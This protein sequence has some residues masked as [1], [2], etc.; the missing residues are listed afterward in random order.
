M[1]Y[2]VTGTAGNDTLNQVGDAGPGTIV[3]L[4]GNDE[5]RTG[6]GAVT[7]DGGSGEDTT[8]LQ[9]GNTGQVTGGV[10]NDSIW[11]ANQNIGSMVLFGNEGADTINVDNSTNP[12]TILGGNDSADAND[13]IRGGGAADIIFGHGGDDR[14]SA[15]NGNDTY[16]A[17]FGNDFMFDPGAGGNDLVFANEGNDS[18]NVWGGNDTVFAGQGND[19]AEVGGGMPTY[20]MNEGNDTFDGSTNVQ[21]MTVVGGNDS[22]DGSD[23]ILTGTGDDL[24]F[25]NGG[26]DTLLVGTGS[27]T[28]IGGAG[29][30]SIY[31]PAG[32]GND[33][34]FGNEGNDTINTYPGSD[35]VFAG[36]GN[37]SVLGN[38][39]TQSYL[40]GEGNDTLRGGDAI[41]TIS[42][43]SG[44]DVFAYS[45][46]D[47]DGNNA[48]AGGPIE[49]L[50]DVNFDED[51]FQVVEGIEFAANVGAIAGPNLEASAES[52][53]QAA[54]ALGGGGAI[55][56]AA[57]FSFNGHTYLAINQGGSNVL[58]TDTFDL[59][60]DI[61]GATGTIGTNDFFV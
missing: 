9:A 8:I 52:A 57:Q 40:G 37:D 33:L 34:V 44:A 2:T 25:G 55:D 31:T 29:D 58:F 51:R 39:G 32:S 42:G 46:A 13:S 47:D 61:T 41:D 23:S 27:N 45:D 11:D 26:N 21:A 20:F 5:I 48:N 16:V 3:G 17:G 54:V 18:M 4:A 36:Q 60:F 43:G 56:V 22:N 53:I 50:T 6:T 24:V 10:E 28:A 49:Q 30:D 19:S 12:Q 14:I 59:L 1:A 15:G 7:V 35:T 38:G